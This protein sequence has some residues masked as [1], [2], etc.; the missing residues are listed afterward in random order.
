MAATYCQHAEDLCMNGAAVITQYRS[1]SI[2]GNEG[3]VTM[4]T[5]Q[6]SEQEISSAQCRH[7]A[8][9]V[10]TGSPRGSTKLHQVYYAAFGVTAGSL[11]DCTQ[12]CTKSTMSPSALPL[13]HSWIALRIAPSPLCRLRRYRWISQ[14]LHSGLHQVH[15]V[16]FGVSTGSPRGSTKLHQVYYAAFGVTTGSLRIAPSPLCRLRRNHWIT[17]EFHEVAP[18]LSPS[19]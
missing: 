5:R 15:Y 17:K 12:D 11:R 1:L 14:G 16:A 3:Y 10:T 6:D 8:F 19:A 7:V 2:F 13:D 4:W 9:G 18:S